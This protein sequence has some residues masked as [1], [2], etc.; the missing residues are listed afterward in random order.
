M[1]RSGWRGVV[2]VGAGVATGEGSGRRRQSD[3][4]RKSGRRCQSGR[5]PPARLT[6]SRSPYL[7]KYNTLQHYILY[8]LIWELFSLP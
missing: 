4:R 1:E 6:L 2:V 5:R 8:L 7:L 3:G